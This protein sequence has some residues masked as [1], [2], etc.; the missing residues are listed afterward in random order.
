M[1]VDLDCTE[2]T[3]LHKSSPNY[4]PLQGYSLQMWGFIGHEY[5]YLLKIVALDKSCFSIAATAA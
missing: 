5:F 1:W 2:C 4:G 3:L